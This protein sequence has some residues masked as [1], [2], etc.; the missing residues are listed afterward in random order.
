MS[1]A[2]DC[3]FKAQSV[4]SSSASRG[5]IPTPEEYNTGLPSFATSLKDDNRGRL[6][7]FQGDWG[8]LPLPESLTC[9][10]FAAHKPLFVCCSDTGGALGLVIPLTFFH[11]LG[12]IRFTARVSRAGNVRTQRKRKARRSLMNGAL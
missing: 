2:L 4:S 9:T 3:H 12:I 11:N 5:S 6:A 10:G 7:G 1:L 8:G